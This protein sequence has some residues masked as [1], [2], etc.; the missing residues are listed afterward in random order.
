MVLCAGKKRGTSRQQRQHGRAQVP[1]QGQGHVCGTQRGLKRNCRVE[2]R[3]RL[4]AD[5]AHG[6]NTSFYYLESEKNVKT[7][8]VFLTY[9][10]PCASYDFLPRQLSF[11]CL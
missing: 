11:C 9:V 1:I 6:I 8:N 3:S 7:G 10:F 5:S 2:S 4:A